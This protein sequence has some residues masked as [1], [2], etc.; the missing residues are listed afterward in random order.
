MGEWEGGSHN[1]AHGEEKPCLPPRQPSFLLI[2]S[3]VVIKELLLPQRETATERQS[4]VCVCVYVC[5]GARV[6]VRVSM[7]V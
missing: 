7:C 4:A 6:C 2:S 3:A 1:V 5:G